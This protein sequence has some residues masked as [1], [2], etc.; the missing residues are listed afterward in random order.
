VIDTKYV[1]PKASATETAKGYGELVDEM[2]REF[3]ILTDGI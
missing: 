3:Q 1:D 2:K